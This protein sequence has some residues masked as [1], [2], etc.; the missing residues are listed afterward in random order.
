MVR[1]SRI[2]NH[3]NDER[4]IMKD[5]EKNIDEFSK[6]LKNLLNKYDAHICFD[7][8]DSSDLY[9][10]SGEQIAIYMTDE[11]VFYASGYSLNKSDL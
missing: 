5:N 2:I 7:C 8:N 10:L 1:G 6:V 11:K 9:G 4:N 3:F